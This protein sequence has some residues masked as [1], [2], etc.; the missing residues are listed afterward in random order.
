MPLAPVRSQHRQAYIQQEDVFYSML[1]AAETLDMAA[2]LR[3]PQ[4]MDAE[5]R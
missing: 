1:T 3:L 4:A 2:Q 5:Q